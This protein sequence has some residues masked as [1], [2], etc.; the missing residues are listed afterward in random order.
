MFMFLSLFLRL[1]LRLRLWLQSWGK[2]LRRDAAARGVVEPL[3]RHVRGASDA[4]ERADRRP[5]EARGQPVA[6]G[7]GGA[8]RGLAAAGLHLG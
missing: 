7:R 3:Q 4:A 6:D 2:N 1:Q 5:P 8:D